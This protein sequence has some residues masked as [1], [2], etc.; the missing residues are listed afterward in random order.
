[1]ET[2]GEKVG[3]T[4]G[5]TAADVSASEKPDGRSMRRT[6]NRDAVLNALISIFE[7][8][9][10]D[11][12]VDDVATRAG[13]SNRSI[14][15]YFDDRD[16]LVRAAI[17]HAMV[18]IGSELQFDAVGLGDFD[19]RIRSFVDHRIR[20]HR[21]LGEITRAARLAART[22]QLIREQLAS[23]RQ[24]LRDSF[25][26]HFAEEL[27]PMSP[28]ERTRAVITVDLAFQFESLEFLWSSTGGD[29]DEVCSILVDHLHRCLG[30][31]SPALSC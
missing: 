3:D 18:T 24:L 25:V 15:R 6:R 10:V 29:A 7:E 14:Y 9:N 2:A 31:L 30:R 4:G 19:E 8:G 5:E 26:A 27:D 20:I 12:S 22:E 16:H 11:P 28:T 23:G 1:M 17:T 21:R 13:V